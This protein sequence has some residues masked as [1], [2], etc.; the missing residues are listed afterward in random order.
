MLRVP[1]EAFAE[2]CE[3]EC[4]SRVVKLNNVGREFLR[5]VLPRVRVLLAPSIYES[6]SYA[7][8]EAL[9]SGTPAVV[10]YA[11]P[12]HVVIDGFN[13]FRIRNPYDVEKFTEKTYELLTDDS[14]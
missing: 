5:Y 4:R 12:G 11:I 9:A 2:E 10:S 6:F 7:T 8:L 13:G 3:G 1:R 14:L